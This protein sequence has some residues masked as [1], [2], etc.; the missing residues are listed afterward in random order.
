MHEYESENDALF[1]AL[2]MLPTLI[3]E[4]KAL[5][6]SVNNLIQENK[7]RNKEETQSTGIST[8]DLVRAV[9]KAIPDAVDKALE[10]KYIRSQL[11]KINNKKNDSTPK[12]KSLGKGCLLILLT[13]IILS[14]AGI[15]YVQ[16]QFKK[17]DLAR[18]YSTICNSE[19]IT[20][21]EK[22]MLLVDLDI[23]SALPK[24]YKHDHKGTA[25]VI[26][27]NKRIIEEREKEAEHNG[28]RWTITQ[29]VKR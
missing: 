25:K 8:W 13:Y 26:K 11:F 21:D 5:N 27:Q 6:E 4:T 17:E 14:V 1:E 2:D 15:A 22:E 9:Q 23:L 28:G 18:L 20:E 10:G 24:E 12:E 3:R 19:F 29:Q 16:S 7:Y